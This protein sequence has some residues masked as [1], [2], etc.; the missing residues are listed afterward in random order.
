MPSFILCARIIKHENSP[1]APQPRKTL[2]HALGEETL[3]GD[4]VRVDAIGRPHLA[5][6]RLIALGGARMHAHSCT[7]RQYCQALH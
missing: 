5:G 4:D 2:A 1:V 6:V 3:H 7:N